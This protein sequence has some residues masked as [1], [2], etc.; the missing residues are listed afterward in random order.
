MNTHVPITQFHCLSVVASLALSLCPSTLSPS[1]VNILE[2][3]SQ[4]AYNLIYKYFTMN[5]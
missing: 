1:H 4:V 3:K 5:L 2:K